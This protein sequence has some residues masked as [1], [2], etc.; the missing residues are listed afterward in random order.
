MKR[1]LYIS[2]DGLLDPLGSSQ[3]LPYISGSSKSDLIFFI[4]T[5]EN[6]KNINKIK[7]LKKVIE[8]NKNLH[9]EYFLFKKKR[10][11]INRLIELILLYTLTLKIFLIKKINI[12]HSRSYLP[13]FICIFLKLFS[14]V[15]IIFDTRG[16]WF[17]ERIE[18]G[19]LKQKGL[20]LIIYKILKK[21]E[22]LLFKFSDYI[23]FLTN[24]GSDKVNKSFIKNKNISI[25]PCAADYNLFKILDIEKK[26]KIKESLGLKEK[27]IIT[28]SGSLGS[29][30]NF[31]QIKKFYSNLLSRYPNIFLIVLTQSDIH[32]ELSNLSDDIKNKI[33]FIS[34]KREFIPEI[35]G[36]SDLTLCFIKKTPSKIFSSPTKVGESLGCGVP[37]VYNEGIGDLDD[38][39]ESM[40]LGFRLNQNGFIDE[41][42]LE[43]IFLSSNSKLEIR[44]NSIKKYGLE[45]AV[46]KFVEIYKSI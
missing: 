21:I 12:L 6:K 1:I 40:K 38:D 41:E 19:M 2:V 33:I 7:N 16:S 42:D 15:K 8:K 10:G 37:V 4:C 11:K 36:V 31:D 13:M 29:W 35:I 9:W 18:G 46:K 28:Y 25:I 32:K 24:N 39:M 17:D 27:F 44:E 45:N 30:Y 20:D 3:I 43:K 34:A 26:N 23:I 14:K 5:I 22:F